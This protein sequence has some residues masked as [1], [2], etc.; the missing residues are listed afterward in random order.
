[1]IN[2]SIEKETELKTIHT[3]SYEVMDCRIHLISETVATYSSYNACLE[4]FYKILEEAK[5]AKIDLVV[6]NGLGEPIFRTS[7]LDVNVVNKDY[8]EQLYSD[9][10][11]WFGNPSVYNSTYKDSPNNGYEFYT[12]PTE[13]WS[14]R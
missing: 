6:R 5:H 8:K 13:Q 4:K 10:Y 1:M 9:P 11:G 3:L 14:Y 7:L 2:S 12:K